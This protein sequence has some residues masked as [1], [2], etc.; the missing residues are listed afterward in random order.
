MWRGSRKIMTTGKL[1]VRTVEPSD[2]DTLIEFLSNFEDDKRG[3]EEWRARLQLWWDSNPAFSDE[4]I[5]GWVLLQTD[6][7]K[8]VGFLGNVPSFFQYQSEKIIVFS[9]TTWRVDNEY[10]NKSLPLLFEFINNAKNS[11]V[12][13]ATPSNDVI[14]I[15]EMLKFRPLPVMTKVTYCTFLD[16][17]NLVRTRISKNKFLI[18]LKPA[19]YLLKLYHTLR[20]SSIDRKN[21]VKRITK[22]DSQFDELWEKTKNKFKN[23]RVRTSDVINWYCFDN[24]NLN[25]VLFGYFHKG[26]LQAYAIFNIISDRDSKQLI[27]ADVWGIQINKKIVK[28]FCAAAMRYANDNK[29]DMIKYPR[30]DDSLGQ[31]LHSLGLF[32]IKSI[33]KRYLKTSDE[34]FDAINNSSTYFTYFQGDWGL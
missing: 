18:A 8:I 15:F 23:T 24:I 11:I 17:Y 22:A 5:R 20:L 34:K 3:L 16:T 28:S 21:T 33:D 6:D 25:K 29:I 26:E 12:C 14:K 19:S 27:C 30:F 7:N 31:I 1:K 10:R 9:T 13:E 32:Q 2:Y 4:I